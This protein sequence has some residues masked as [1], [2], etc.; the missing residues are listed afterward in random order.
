MKLTKWQEYGKTIVAAFW[1]VVALIIA[2]YSGDGRIDTIEGI[3]LATAIGNVIVVYIVP[4]NESFRTVKSAV[5]ALLAA[6]AVAQV[7]IGNGGWSSLDLNDWYQII[8]AALLSLGVLVAPA[9]SLRQ[10]V[11]VRVRTGADA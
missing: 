11:P 4:L 10:Q 7:L 1:P 9:A 8:A 6:I 3:V 5:N 2:Q